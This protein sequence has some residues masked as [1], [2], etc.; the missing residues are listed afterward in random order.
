MNDYLIAKLKE[1]RLNRGLKQS[2][3]TKFTGIKN[4]TL[5]N[6]ENG[7]TE[8]DIDTF[9]QLCELYGI[10]YAEILGEAYGLNVQG[11]DFDIK[12]SE[13]DHIKKYRALDDIG[14]QHVDTVLTWETERVFHQNL[15]LENEKRDDEVPVYILN[16]YQRLASA[17]SGEYLFD[18]I[19]TD[20]IEVPITS[21]SEQADFVIGV[22][23][24]SMEP[25]YYDG[26]KVYVK[27][28]DGI[29]I[30]S[31]GVFTRGNEC[32]IKELGINCLKSHNKG[33]EDIPANNDIRLVGEVLGKLEED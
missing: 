14:R 5:S 26:D 13:I 9:L 19:P 7:I 16:Y 27:I 30:G 31:I 25:T 12:P 11:S 18:N 3:V 1:G 24:H 28:T 2:D 20:T 29:P 17:G 10:D 22:N 23:G 21:T 15:H 32:F 8:P 33:Y 4:T 6:Y